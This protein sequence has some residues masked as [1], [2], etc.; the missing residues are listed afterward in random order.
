MTGAE[1]ISKFLANKGVEVM[2]GYPGASVLDLYDSISK[3][4]IKHILMRHEQGASLAASG[5]AK[6]SGRVGICI[7][8]SGP[9]AANLVTGIADAYLDS[10]PMLIITGQVDT[11]FIGRDAFQEA[12]ILGITMPI[13]K[14]SYLVRSPALL[15]KCLWE[16]WNVAISDRPGPVLI[17]IAQDIF[18]AEFDDS[19]PTNIVLPRKRENVATVESEL[20]QI[21]EALAQSHR[22]LILAG[23]GVVAGKASSILSR[24]S[25][26]SGIPI[27]FTLPGMGLSIDKEYRK[28]VNILGLAGIYGSDAANA[29]MTQ[30]DLV[31]AVGC[32]MSDRTIR[33]FKHFSEGRRII[34][35]DIDPAEINKNVI[36]DI[37]VVSDASYFLEALCGIDTIQPA[38]S[39]ESWNEY[40]KSLKT[41]KPL[42]IPEN[43]LSCR[44]ILR[45]LNNCESRR[46]DALYV[47]DVGNH[48]MRA[49][50]EIEP[51]FERGFIT[52]CGLGAMGFGLPGAI[53]ASFSPPEGC[54]Q[55][56]AICGDGGFQ[57]TVEELAVLKGTK[58]PIKI[59]LCDNY[60]LGMIRKM[61]DNL[62]D[63][64]HTDSEL[65]FNPDFELLAKAYGLTT[66][67]LDVSAR[68]T[69]EHKIAEILDRSENIFVHCITGDL[70]TVTNS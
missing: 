26:K 16:A 59:F 1:Y 54:K 58:L 61:Q 7:A 30:C 20:D 60:S 68:D 22:P 70:E 15:K 5:Y 49:A 19:D 12:D 53:G 64:R 23:G 21:K 29:A 18:K 6:A 42:T 27:A 8:T 51:C 13:T 65:D 50:R 52:S 10:A 28:D 56:I 17:D 41:R 43:F 9:G 62:Y 35:C 57:M 66:V 32:R 45:A 48:Q 55:I 47:T 34:H 2:F 25:A 67:R 44:E 38:E 36:A 33:N 40:L 14:H 46:M 39:F 24:F 69:L 37:P 11:S 4:N 63:G 31:I 3:T